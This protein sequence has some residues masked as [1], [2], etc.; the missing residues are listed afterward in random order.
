VGQRLLEDRVVIEG[1]PQLRGVLFHTFQL[2][3]RAVKIQGSA[4]LNEGYAFMDADEHRRR[5]PWLTWT[6]G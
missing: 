1:K 2:A 3:V 5:P 4:N 6:S